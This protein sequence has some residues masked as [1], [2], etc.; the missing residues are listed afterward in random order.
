MRK[1]LLKKRISDF[2]GKFP[3]KEVDYWQIEKEFGRTANPIII[4][5]LKNCELAEVRSSRIR[6]W[7][8]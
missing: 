5:M 3:D 8:R 6:I 2:I 1:P 7:K 4:D